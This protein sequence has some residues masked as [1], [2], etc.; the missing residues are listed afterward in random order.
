MS[1]Q[2]PDRNN[3]D[4]NLP[5]RT[6]DPGSALSLWMHS[7]YGL[8]SP[9]T[10]D[11]YLGRQIIV[12]MRYQGG[13]EEL[14][15]ELVPG[16]KITLLRE[17]ENRFDHRAVMALDAKG[18]KLGYIPRT[19]N[20]I[21]SALMDAGKVFYGVIPDDSGDDKEQNRYERNPFT[22]YFDLYMRELSLPDDLTEIPRQGYRGSYVVL[23][24]TV[25][26]MEIT[27]L[28]AIKVINGE[29]RGILLE[30]DSGSDPGTGS[31]G[32][33][34]LE[35]FRKF[36]GY[37]P[38][39]CH[40][41]DAQERRALEESY[42]VLLGIPFSN[43]VIDTLKMAENHIQYQDSYDLSSLADELGINVDD[44]HGLERECRIIWQLY[45][46]MERSEVQLYKDIR[47]LQSLQRPQ[48]S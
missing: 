28:C 24:I 29:E 7:E 46:R 12:G 47:P 17:S 42:G 36:A 37:L 48:R 40:N 10:R 30:E 32:R 2:D 18:R 21:I 20:R 26:D 13:A 6:D 16:E 43:R 41:F 14:V 45:C 27:G 39:V 8:S 25:R 5:S 1:D 15:N 35:R 23:S 38:F 34:R 11:I 3:N 44:C 33:D 9:F 31:D 19:E 22:L 4:R